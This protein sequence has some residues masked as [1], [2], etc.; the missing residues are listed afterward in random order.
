ME[1]AQKRIASL[2]LGQ[3][4]WNRSRKELEANLYLLPNSASCIWIPLNGGTKVQS[5]T[6]IMAMQIIN[7]LG[8]QRSKC[9]GRH[10]IQ[11]SR[12]GQRQGRKPG[13]GARGSDLGGRSIGKGWDQI[14]VGI[15]WHCGIAWCTSR[16]LSLL[17]RSG[18]NMMSVW[19]GLIEKSQGGMAEAQCKMHTLKSYHELN[20]ATIID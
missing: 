1:S 9:Q 5:L 12:R 13:N 18:R 7:S 3:G 15:N 14:A 2:S 8:A 10:K 17:L 19:D 20:W 11:K 6:T 4:P 16:H